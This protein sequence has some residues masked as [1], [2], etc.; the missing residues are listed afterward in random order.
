MRLLE[1]VVALT[2]GFLVLGVGLGLL[3]RAAVTGRVLVERAE[4]IETVRLTPSVLEAELAG[5]RPVVDWSGDAAGVSIRAFRGV[6]VSCADAGPDPAPG[7]ALVAYRGLRQPDPTKDSLEL[8]L[9]DGRAAVVALAS[10]SSP[11]VVDDAPACG[12]SAVR[13]TWTDSAG[14]DGWVRLPVVLVR[15][16]ERGLYAVDDA[17]RYR[18]GAGGRQ[19]LTDAALDPSVSWLEERSGTPTLRVGVPGA[20]GR[21]R[22]FLT[23]GPR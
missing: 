13:V 12:D 22:V 11:G 1:V 23:V 2:V 3:A 5:A 16:F 17:L 8:V 4:A 18:R 15:V 9:A 7:S 6:G 14:V 10:A 20:P 19:P 21:E